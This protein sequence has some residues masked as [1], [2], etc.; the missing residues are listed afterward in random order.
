MFAAILVLLALPLL[1]TSKVRGLQFKPMSKV[2][3]WFFIANFLTLMV[4]GAKHVETPYIEIGQVC[5]FLYF[6]WFLLLVPATSLFD[7]VFA[8]VSLSGKANKPLFHETRV[9]GKGCLLSQVRKYSTSLTGSNLTD[10]LQ[11]AQFELDS[12]L[13]NYDPASIDPATNEEF[14]QLANGVFQSEGTVSARIKNNGK[15]LTIEPFVTMGQNYT[16]EALKFFVR[17]YYAT[18][19]IGKINLSVTLSGKVYIRWSSSSWKNIVPKLSNY[20]SSLYGE[21]FIAFQKLAIINDLRLDPAPQSKI[22]AVKLV[23]S[24]AKTGLERKT[25]LIAQLAELDLPYDNKE[26]PKSSGILEDNLKIPSFLFVLGF[27]LGDGSI[28]VR[29]RQ[30]ASGS[31]NFIPMIIFPQKTTKENGHLF[32]M[33][34]EF[35]KK[36]GINTNIVNNSSGMTLINVE[37]I[38][39]VS[40]LVPLFAANRSYSYW[41]FANINLLL[42]FFKAISIGVH[43]YRKGVVALL[44]I[45]Y[46]HPNNREKLIEIWI[47]LANLYFDKLEGELISGHHLIQPQK[48]RGDLANEIIGWRV[49]FPTKFKEGQLIKY[50]QFSTYGSKE[51]ALQAA[52]SYRD[53]IL[54]KHLEKL[55]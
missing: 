9:A 28:F 2:V 37:G 48:G 41:K 13:R 4:L 39:A 34:S 24:L 29:I 55:S 36:L 12:A 23:Y 8:L 42:D 47:S 49:V 38:Q 27:I 5:T 11:I 54:A 32:T 50:F 6:S 31:L 43:T 20:F 52:V 3:F 40:F 35:F 53:T 51:K 22:E 1:D 33:L 21:K 44:G 19:R 16:P 26:E 17:L 30:T 25:A 46:K 7:K 15:K 10:S 45:L 14:R 18:E